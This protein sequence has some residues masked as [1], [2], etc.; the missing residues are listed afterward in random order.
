MANSFQPV[1]RIP[2]G[3]LSL[4]GLK[5]NGNNPRSMLDEYRPVIES[6]EWLL[7]QERE[8][9]GGA[10][11][12]PPGPNIA[13]ILA[14]STATRVPD[15]EIWYVW[16]HTVRYESF[17][18]GDTVQ[19]LVA[20]AWQLANQSVIAMPGVIYNGTAPSPFILAVGYEPRRFAHARDVL[21]ATCS[22]ITVGAVNSAMVIQAEITRLKL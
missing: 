6:M 8:V 12:L 14:P 11:A 21:G 19:G 18:A 4:T 5:V 10:V 13:F 9:V 15:D 20:P 3:L 22:L 1:S 7:A 2:P 16:N 17:N